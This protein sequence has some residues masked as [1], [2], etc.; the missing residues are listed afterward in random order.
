MIGFL[1]TT[2]SLHRQKIWFRDEPVARTSIFPMFDQNGQ[3]KQLMVILPSIDDIYLI[4]WNPGLIKFGFWGTRRLMLNLAELKSYNQLST[5]RFS[6]L[7]YYDPLWVLDNNRFWRYREFEQLKQTNCA[8]KFE[9]KI[10]AACFDRNLSRLKKFMVEHGALNFSYR[11]AT[12]EEMTPRSGL[13]LP[14]L[15]NETQK[16]PLSPQWRLDPVW[17]D[18]EKRQKI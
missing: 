5:T 2:E 3:I 10:A 4:P 12:L 9:E 15:K 1:L 6:N 13:P 16:N 17:K 11:S 8:N 14:T 7:W 18:W